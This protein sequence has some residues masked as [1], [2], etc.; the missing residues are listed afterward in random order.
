MKWILSI[1]LLL[2]LLVIAIFSLPFL[3]DLTKYQEQYRPVI[4][5]ALNRKVTL[6]NI[7]LT[8][9]PR[10]GARVTGFTVQDDPGFRMGPFASLDSL[11]VGVK[12][13]PLLSGK[14]E[15]EEITLREPAITVLKNTQGLM[16]ISTLGAQDHKTPEKRDPAEK[17]SDESAL[18]I[19][20]LLAVDRVGITHGTLTYRDEST[21]TPTEYA[22]QNLEFLLRSVRLGQTPTLHVTAT[23]QPYNLPVTIT[24]A[25]GPLVD[26]LDFKQ[27]DL[28]LALGKVLLS[29]KGSAVAGHA[30]GTLTSP[31]IHSKDLPLALPLTKPVVVKDLLVETEAAYPPKP[32][33]PPL[34]MATVKALR[35]AIVMG[36]STIGLTGTLKGGRLSVAATSKSVNTTDL[37]VAVPLKKP[38]E[39][40]DLD[41]KAELTQ[42]QAQVSRLAFQLFGGQVNGRAGLALGSAAPPFDAQL[43]VKGVQLGPVIDAFATDKALVSGTASTD[44]TLRGVGFS[45]PEL[46]RA[47]TGTGH[48]VV[49]DGK[50]DGVNLTQE[51]LNAFKVV[52]LSAGDVKATAFSTIEGDVAIQQ[53]VVQLQRFLADSH[54]FQATASGTIGFDQTVNV[55]ATINLSEALSQKVAGASAAARLMATKGR[56]SVPLTITGTTA[57]PSYG[58]DVTAVAGKVG[59]QLKEKVGEILKG[60]P[61]T[62]KLI[63]Q[64]GDTLKS[65]FGK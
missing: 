12:L 14:V 33:A 9:W 58:V 59:Q 31:A 65:L 26:S 63:Q 42:Q 39:I 54:D 61:A 17:P 41:L 7:R 11:D 45:V 55:K 64:G 8:I 47:L 37:P 23:V 56:I 43:A 22:V 24:G 30:H 2:L 13:L 46:T 62:E 52:G 4:E 15:V 44:V 27:I 1:G 53:G 6:Q 21:P 10:I 16:N 5:Q 18:N 49:K 38:I 29:L 40:K 25:A 50:L 51:V 32:G 19:L 36:N 48:L 35:A 20:A 57:A 28:D 3:I 60:S 34:E